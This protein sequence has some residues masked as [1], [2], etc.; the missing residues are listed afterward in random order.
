MPKL[1]YIKSF[2]EDLN[3]INDLHLN[4]GYNYEHNI[5]KNVVSQE[6]F[7]NPV[8]DTPYR[9]IERLIEHLINEVKQI[10]LSYAFAFP[11]NSKYI[12]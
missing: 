3:H 2:K 7:L 8:N 10:K 6:L 5:L 11:K 1:K 9:Q 12:N 4:M